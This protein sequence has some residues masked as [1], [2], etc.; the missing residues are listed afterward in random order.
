LILLDTSVAIPI[1]DN[2]TAVIER[3]RRSRQDPAISIITQVELFGGVY[4]RKADPFRSE[5]LGLFLQ[6]VEVLPL[7]EL[8]AVL[9]A[10][11]IDASG[12]SRRKILD[13]LIAATALSHD[14]PLATLNPQDFADVG[15]LR[16]VD[17]SGGK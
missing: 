5:L 8:E 2:E 16:I 1:R 3:L 6:T 13:R 7:T 14:L 9:Y 4:G 15:G 10:A 12:F 17:W 11:I